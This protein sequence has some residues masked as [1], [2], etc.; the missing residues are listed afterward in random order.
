[1]FPDCPF[2]CAEGE[3]WGGDACVVRMVNIAELRGLANGRGD[4]PQRDCEYLDGEHPNL[5][6]FSLWSHLTEVNTS[7][8]GAK[9]SSTSYPFINRSNSEG[10]GMQQTSQQPRHFKSGRNR[11]SDPSSHNGD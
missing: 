9:S 6:E 10:I 5:E 2:R 8:R 11:H 4:S 1:M 7:Q 3:E